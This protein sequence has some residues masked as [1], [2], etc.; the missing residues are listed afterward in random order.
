MAK[1]QD[2]KIIW[3]CLVY[4]TSKKDV[5]VTHDKIH[6]QKGGFSPR[7]RHTINLC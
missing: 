5:T 3:F 6:C 1:N 2:E 7:S 4:P